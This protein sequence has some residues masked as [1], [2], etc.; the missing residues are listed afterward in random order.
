MCYCPSYRSGLLLL[1]N[2]GCFMPWSAIIQFL[3]WRVSFIGTQRKPL[4][5][6]RN[7]NCLSF[8]ILLI[9]KL[10]ISS[11]E[12]IMMYLPHKLIRVFPNDRPNWPLHSIFWPVQKLTSKIIYC[13]FDEKDS[14]SNF[15]EWKA[16]RK[17]VLWSSKKNKENTLL[18]RLI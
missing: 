16:I 3:L 17:R 1:W 9:W 5:G 6:Q 15:L 8:I 7:C 14:F 12:N 4:P 10:I 13:D 11:Q 18:S 2:H